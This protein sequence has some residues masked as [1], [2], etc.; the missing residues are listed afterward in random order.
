IEL[1]TI[2]FANTL[3]ISNPHV[4]LLATEAEDT[5]A[6]PATGDA[7]ALVAMAAKGVIT[8][9]LLEGPLAADCA[10]SA[11]AARMLGV[12]SKIAGQVDVVIVP[13]LEA[14]ALML[15]TMTGMFGGVAAGLGLG[16]K[17]PIV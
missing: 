3:G 2:Y 13:S 9:G 6:L 4:A 10:F 1:S 8:G 14:G 11:A 17:V 7:A 5:A 15:R 12:E 16:S